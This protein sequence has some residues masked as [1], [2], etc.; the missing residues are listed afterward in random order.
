MELCCAVPTEV[1]T[2]DNQIDDA[3]GLIETSIRYVVAYTSTRQQQRQNM[4]M[5]F[6]L[7]KPI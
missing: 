2:R 1:C 3:F 4:S 5:F 6:S 7:K